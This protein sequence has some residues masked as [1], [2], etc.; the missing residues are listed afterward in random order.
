MAD[1]DESESITDQS[2]LFMQSGEESSRIKKSEGS[3]FRIFNQLA[4]KNNKKSQ[5]NS[6]S[7]ER[8]M[9]IK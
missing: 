4:E 6:S 1:I 7:N 9:L 3:N 5:N 2:V 8:S